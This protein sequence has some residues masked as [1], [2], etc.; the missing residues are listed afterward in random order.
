ML[1]PLLALSLLPRVDAAAEIGHFVGLGRLRGTIRLSLDLEVVRGETFAVS[2]YTDALS[3]VRRNEGIESPVRIS[4]QQ[5]WYPVGAR[6]R[7]DLPGD[8]AWGL[9]AFHQSNHD[10]DTDDA[11]LN[12]ETV[13]FEVY[14]AEY[15]M[16]RLRLWAGLYYDRGT[17]LDGRPQTLP[18][19]YYLGGL[20][21]A[22]ELPLGPRWY[23]AGALN[24]V[25][26]RNGSHQIPHL[27][28]PGQLEAG[29]RF[30]G[31]G[32][33]LRVF[34]RGQRV[35]DYQHLGDT[36]EHLLLLGL[37]LGSEVW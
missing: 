22:G 14:G 24:P 25:F 29:L 8:R 34:V 36:P 6:I 9:F 10:V 30:A 1:T 2:I 16:P 3:F 19:D 27:N 35:E 4:P 32:G 7:W 12:N 17:R 11:R 20:S 31:E 28:L 37:G 5:I 23:L 18:F 21:A 15:V 33:M 26:H 13:S